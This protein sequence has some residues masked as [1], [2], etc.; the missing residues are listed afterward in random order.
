MN[1]C[2]SGNPKCKCGLGN[3][4]KAW[5]SSVL[6]ATFI[7]RAVSLRN[8]K[9]ST[10]TQEQCSGHVDPNTGTMLPTPRPKHRNNAP[11]TATQTQQQCSR[12]R[13]PNTGTMLRTRWPKHRNNAPDTATQ[14]FGSANIRLNELKIAAKKNPHI[15]KCKVWEAMPLVEDGG[16]GGPFSVGS[17]PPWGQTHWRSRGAGRRPRVRQGGV[18]KEDRL[19]SSRRCLEGERRWADCPFKKLRSTAWTGVATRG[20]TRCWHQKPIEWKRDTRSSSLVCGHLCGGLE[21]RGKQKT[22]FTKTQNVPRSWSEAPE[23]RNTK[24]KSEKHS[25][26]EEAGGRHAG[27]CEC[28]SVFVVL[29]L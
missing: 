17:W 29:F 4:P 10:Q 1:P 26:H 3:R 9:A 27:F 13:D 8:A 22:S 20:R 12:H 25:D 24:K 28:S 5:S 2:S 15:L 18:W 23:F 21:P 11:D 19:M 6:I 16:G 14:T 7:L